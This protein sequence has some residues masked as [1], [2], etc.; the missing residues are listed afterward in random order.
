MA[1]TRSAQATVLHLGMQM[2]ALGSEIPGNVG[3]GG[4]GKGRDLDGI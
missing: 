4:F 3:G 2:R 1:T